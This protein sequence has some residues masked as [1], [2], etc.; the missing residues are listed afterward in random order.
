MVSFLSPKQFSTSVLV[1]IGQI[2][3]QKMFQFRLRLVLEQG[4]SV[5]S[6]PYPM[7][8]HPKGARVDHLK[9]RKQLFYTTNWSNSSENMTRSIIASSADRSIFLLFTGVGKEMHFSRICYFSRSQM[10]K[11]NIDSI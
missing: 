10:K 11:L 8:V 7:G 4:A 9:R 5:L 6:R 3:R 2:E 1:A